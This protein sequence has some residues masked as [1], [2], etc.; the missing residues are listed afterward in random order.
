MLLCPREPDINIEEVKDGYLEEAL[1]VS[2]KDR[3]PFAEV[4]FHEKYINP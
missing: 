2:E 3:K 4:V 1:S